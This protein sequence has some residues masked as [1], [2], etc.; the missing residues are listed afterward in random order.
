MKRLSRAPFPLSSE[1]SM[2]KVQ[3]RSRP[4]VALSSIYFEI[5]VQTQSRIRSP[6]HLHTVGEP[7]HGISVLAAGLLFPAIHDGGQASNPQGSRLRLCAV[8][9]YQQD[10]PKRLNNTHCC[11]TPVL[12]PKTLFLVRLRL[13]RERERDLTAGRVLH[14]ILPTDVWAAREGGIQ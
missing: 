1:T 5:S 9:I 2:P 10:W 8:M 7:V 14:T 13:E 3:T 12:R 11:G 4:A 6:H